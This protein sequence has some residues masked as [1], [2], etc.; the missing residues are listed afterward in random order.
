MSIAVTF[1]TFTKRSNSTKIPAAGGIE[2]DCIIKNGTAVIAPVIELDLGMST[3]PSELN[4][5]YIPKFER[6]YYV[7]DWNFDRALW[8]AHLQ[9]DVLGTYKSQIGNA[10]LYVLRA[11]AEN[12]GSVI[13]TL[14][15]VKSGCTFGR[16]TLET[17]WTLIA[18]AGTYVV[19]IVSQS[20]LSLGSVS[21]YAMSGSAISDLVDALIDDTVT[22]ANGYSVDDGTMALQLSLV[23]PIQY[24]KSCVYLPV[25]S[26][27]G[28]PVLN[29]KVFKWSTGVN[30]TAL[31]TPYLPYT[32][33]LSF[34][35]PKHP[36]TSSRGNYT[37]TAP[38]TVL[39]LSVPPFGNIEIDTSV[40][41]NATTLYAHIYLD[42]ITG[43]G[44]M[45]VECNS[46]VLSRIEAQIGVPIS[47]SEVTRD[48]I[49][50]ATSI[51]SSI[52]N[53]VSG[54]FIG[55]AAGIGS[56]AQA[57][58]PRSSTIGTTGSFATLQGTPQLNAQFFTIVDDDNTSNGRPLCKIRKPSDLGG[59]MLIQDADVPI[60]GTKTEADQIRTLLEGGF[61][62]E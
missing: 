56:A 10:N 6:Y 27:T 22:P 30:A 46:V 51:L 45:I 15:P 53:A 34:N 62:Y 39:T 26:I 50:G 42:M 24:I 59:Y 32:V 36:Q 12:D 1:Y 61:Y 33:N 44:V 8:T 14:Y 17:P 21:Y 49:G 60:A 29:L 55:A 28:L 3:D 38:Y 19:G 5:C 31:M 43:K 13:D 52:G 2:Y 35:I 7:T 37:N 16:T 41:A 25:D 58:A 54:N 20:G 4:Y 48:Y 9:V 23:N 40:T 11:S 18:P 57:L 47:L